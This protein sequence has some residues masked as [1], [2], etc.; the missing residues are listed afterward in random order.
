[1]IFAKAEGQVKGI[2]ESI[3]FTNQQIQDEENSFASLTEAI[4]TDAFGGGIETG[5]IG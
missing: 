2:D 5:G 3:A 1:M 4:V